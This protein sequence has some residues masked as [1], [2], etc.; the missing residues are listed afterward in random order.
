MYT[1][2]NAHKCIFSYPKIKC[3]HR[4]HKDAAVHPPPIQ[5]NVRFFESSIHQG[6]TFQLRKG[7]YSVGTDKNQEYI[8]GVILN[9]ELLSFKAPAAN[10]LTILRRVKLRIDDHLQILLIICF[11]KNSDQNTV[12]LLSYSNNST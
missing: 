8:I 11:S 3:Y 9:G 6:R 4:L 10:F 2:Y 1:I 5:L 7:F 12:M